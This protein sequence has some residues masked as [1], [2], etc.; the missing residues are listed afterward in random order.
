MTQPVLEA[1]QL[2]KTFEAVTAAADVSVAVPE[3]QVLGIIGANGAGKTTFVNMVTGYLKPS[4]GQIL[5]RGRDITPLPPREVTRAGICRSFQVAQLFPDLTVLENMLVALGVAA[6][7]RPAFWRPLRVRSRIQ[8]AEDLLAHYGLSEHRD[9]R[10]AVLPQG[11]RKVLDIAMAMVA[12]PSV[13]LLDEPTSGIS[14][15]EKFAIMDGVMSVLRA[16]Q[17]TVLFVEHDMEIVERFAQR[18]VAFYDGRIIADGSPAD[19][20]AS[21]EVRRFVVGTELHRRH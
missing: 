16:A 12:G 14:A 19:V 2:H 3:G 13:L 6:A 20:L 15:D 7:R 5:Y 8:K 1:R 17:V 10:T 4:R 21:S 18:V 9:R 11:V